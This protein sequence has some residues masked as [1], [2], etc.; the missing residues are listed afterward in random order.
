M[1]TMVLHVMKNK[2]VGEIQNEFMTA[3]PYLKIDFFEN[4]NTRSNSLS[5]NR[6]NSIAS[7]YKTGMWGEGPL[8]ISDT[9]TVEELEALFKN[10]FGITAQV[11]RKSGGIWLETI[12]TGDWTLRQQNQN[13]RELS[14]DITRIQTE[15][16]TRMQTGNGQA[17]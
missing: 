10:Q 17:Q 4:G 8:E 2:I 16:V 6:L 1:N 13:G 5:K 7:L 15:D 12:I 3:F 14:E 9:M 11:S